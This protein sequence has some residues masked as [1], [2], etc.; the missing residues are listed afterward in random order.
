MCL[1]AI[2]VLFIVDI[3]LTLRRNKG[4]QTDEE[5]QWGFGQIL[6]LL[7]LVMPLRDA[8]NALRRIRN[9]F[10]QQ[11]EQI[12]LT[13]IE[14]KSSAE[15]IN[16]L[17]EL[18]RAGA[19][20]QKSIS[21]RFENFLQLAAYYGKRD[22]VDFLLPVDGNKRASVD[23]LGTTMNLYQVNDANHFQVGIMERR[24]RLHLR[25]ATIRL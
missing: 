11:F 7:L 5:G 6:A 17:G 14:A 13:V 19:N 2:N 24:F 1:V 20:P 15:T 12:F 9:R 8:W 3:E 10:Q 25:G 4:H 22:L 21:G 16:D 23:A 18:V